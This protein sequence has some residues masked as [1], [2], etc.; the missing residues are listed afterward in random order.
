MEVDVANERHWWKECEVGEASVDFVRRRKKFGRRSWGKLFG[1]ADVE[2][3]IEKI[4]S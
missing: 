2:Q 1:F 4:L 3:D